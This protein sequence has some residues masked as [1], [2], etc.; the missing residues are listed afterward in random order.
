LV[1]VKSDDKGPEEYK[2]KNVVAAPGNYQLPNIPAYYR[3]LGSDVQQLHVGTCTNPGAI[4]D[5]SWL[6]RF[7]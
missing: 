7:A 2:A 1:T 3:N 6:G 5:L 4:A